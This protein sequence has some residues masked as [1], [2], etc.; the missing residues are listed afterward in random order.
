VAAL[1]AIHMSG[2]QLFA[3][4][5]HTG[6][7]KGWVPKWSGMCQDVPGCARM[8]CGCGC[9]ACPSALYVNEIF[10]GRAAWAGDEA[11]TNSN[12]VEI[13]INYCN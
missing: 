10:C 5:Q 6:L 1:H 11:R 4:G 8:G 7:S 3:F 12:A 9:A 13:C 2:P